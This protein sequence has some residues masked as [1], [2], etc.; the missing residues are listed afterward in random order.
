MKII[1]MNYEYIFEKLFLF[2]THQ[3]LIYNSIEHKQSLV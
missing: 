3:K 2:V 1:V